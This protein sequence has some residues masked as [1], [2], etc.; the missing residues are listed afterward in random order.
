MILLLQTCIAAPLELCKILKFILSSPTKRSTDQSLTTHKQTFS[1]LLL[2]LNSKT[3]II[4]I[5][6]IK[7]TLKCMDET[8]YLHSTKFSSSNVFSLDYHHYYE[9]EANSAKD[10]DDDQA[11]W[12]CKQK[13]M[14]SLNFNFVLHHRVIE[15]DRNRKYLSMRPYPL[16]FVI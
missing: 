11:T 15:W 1:F 14:V 10:D 6:G 4:H 5:F 13:S 16:S 8:R 12:T 3:F 7:S 2:Q 9:T